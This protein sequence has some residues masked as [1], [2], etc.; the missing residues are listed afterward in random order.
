LA[1]AAE[2]K[3][4]TGRTQ[5]AAAAENG[6]KTKK[7]GSTL[8]ALM[9]KRADERLAAVERKWGGGKGSLVPDF[10]PHAA[11]L[12]PATAKAS[13]ATEELLLAA[14][15][16]DAAA[17]YAA[18]EKGG[19]PSFVFGEAYGCRPGTGYTALM[20][21]AHRGH[22]GEWF[23]G[24]AGVWVSASVGRSRSP[25]PSKKRT[26]RN[27]PEKKPTKEPAKAMLR[28]GADPN[29]PAPSGDLPLFWAIDGGAE[30][31]QLFVRYGADLDRAAPA[32]W[33]GP[34]T[35]GGDGDTTKTKNDPST[36]EGV[37][38]LSYA[39]AKGKY[40]ATEDAGVYPED[41]LRHYGATKVGAPPGGEAPPP[42]SPRE[43]FSLA[44]GGFRRERGSYQAPMPHP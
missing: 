42:R 41:V 27:K 33:G 6:N 36:L 18:L 12:L 4:P 31:L 13:R 5:A 32:P 20:A 25:P 30:M 26:R 17:A 44:K 34:A 15:T 3:T 43:S 2:T 23:G 9:K 35:G 38:A 10:D 39:I 1:A 7:M 11:A 8:E 40:G 24:G 14:T 16:G 29:K 28:A 19:D 37:T 21:S 22:I